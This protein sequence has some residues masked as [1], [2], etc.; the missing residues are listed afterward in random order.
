MTK[1]TEVAEREGDVLNGERPPRV[2]V[3]AMAP[4]KG[5]R[6][7]VVK[8]A[9]H[10]VGEGAR[11]DVV[12]AHPTGW[13]ELDERARMHQLHPVERRHPL[14]WLERAVVIGL[15]RA[16]VWPL[17]RLGRAGALL[18]R[19]QSRISS[20]VHRRVWQPFYQHIRPLILSRAARRRVLPA[21]DMAEVVR[22]IVADRTAVP[23]GWRLARRYPGLTVTTRMEKSIDGRA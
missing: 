6:K 14:P 16:A 18:E 2:V 4:G 17:A 21:I 1:V 13:D 7:S 23:F 12:T 19:A 15:P 8:L 22:V 11:V 9:N 5:R 10:L 20:G 3:L